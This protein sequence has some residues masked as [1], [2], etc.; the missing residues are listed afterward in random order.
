MDHSC[1]VRIPRLM[2]RKLLSQ[3]I[4]WNILKINI[5]IYQQGSKLAVMDPRW[6]M[7]LCARRIN[8]HFLCSKQWTHFEGLGTF[9]HCFY[10]WSE[11]DKPLGIMNTLFQLWKRTNAHSH[12]N[13]CHICL[14]VIHIIMTIIHIFKTPLCFPT[15]FC[16][17]EREC[18]FLTLACPWTGHQ[19]P[20]WV[21]ELGS[22]EV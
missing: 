10:N 21:S 17:T 8:M 15:Y 19:R 5:E 2:S 7:E 4:N 16:Q 6:L 14:Q 3:I 11:Y 9:D 20:E 18:C 1:D 13:F 12:I 22:P